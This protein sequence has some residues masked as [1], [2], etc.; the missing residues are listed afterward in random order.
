MSESRAAAVC[1]WSLQPATPAELVERVR[2]TGA[3][4]VQLALSPMIHDPATWASAIDA[5]RAADLHIVSGMM[6]MAGEDYSSLA[7]IEATGGVR[8]DATWDAN[9]AHATAVIETAAAHGIDMVT[10]HAGFLPPVGDAERATILGRMDAIAAVA[11]AASI[12]LALETGQESAANLLA[13]LDELEATNLRV[14]FDPANMLLYGTGEPVIALQTLRD[15][16]A[17]IHVKDAQPSSVPGEWGTE[18]PAGDGAV[19]WPEFFAVADPLNVTYVVERESGDARIDD[20]RR[21][22]ALLA[23]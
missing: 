7:R 20:V 14:N 1:S 6:E 12:T 10:F 3:S 23:G 21:G 2:A 16:V 17:Q 19:P 22:L 9:L 11:A 4:G 5:V 8:P 18:T 15:H 13:A